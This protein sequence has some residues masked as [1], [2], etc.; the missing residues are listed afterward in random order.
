[1]FAITETFHLRSSEGGGRNFC[2]RSCNRHVPR[3]LPCTERRIDAGPVPSGRCGQEHISAIAEQG[4]QQGKQSGASLRPEVSHFFL[5]LFSL[6]PS[7]FLV[8]YRRVALLMTSA[9]LFSLQAEGQTGV[10]WPLRDCAET[11]DA[12]TGLFVEHTR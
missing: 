1:M 2:F 12:L 6:P 9:F 8:N 7:L 3:G 5:D 10:A 11:L 4:G